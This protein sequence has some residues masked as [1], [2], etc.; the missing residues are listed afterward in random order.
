M[1][2]NPMILPYAT[3]SDAFVDRH[4]EANRL[5]AQHMK[6]KPRMRKH[7]SGDWSCVGDCASSVEASP[8]FAYEVWRMRHYIW[9]TLAL[10]LR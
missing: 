7:G 6:A 9:W 5:L 8:V 10:G 1:T 3:E 2:W 4:A